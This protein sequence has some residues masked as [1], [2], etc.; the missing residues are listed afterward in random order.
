[1]YA[2]RFGCRLDKETEEDRS[3]NALR[4]MEGVRMREAYAEAAEI[5]GVRWTGRRYDRHNWHK[6]DPINKALSAANACM[7]GICHAAI[8]SGGYSTALGFI[9]TGKQLSFVY[10]IGDLYKTEITIPLA[11]RTTAESS[12]DVEERVRYACRDAFRQSRLL[13]RILDEIDALL[14]MP[15]GQERAGPDVDADPAMPA[16]LWEDLWTQSME[17]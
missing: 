14:D 7:Y 16:S 3:L 9:H 1:M 13:K 15:D 2:M 4:G 17:V 11:F 12:D 5:H 10:D 8:V 6:A